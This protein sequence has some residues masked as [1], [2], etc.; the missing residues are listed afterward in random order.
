TDNNS[1]LVAQDVI[2]RVRID[3]E[4]RRPVRVFTIAYSPDARQSVDALRAIAQASGGNA[5]QGSTDNI[6]SIYRE[7]ASFF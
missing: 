2:D 7:V 1:R 4:A 5:Y 3:P 6:V